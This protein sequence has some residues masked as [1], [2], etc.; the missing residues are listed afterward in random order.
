MRISISGCVYGLKIC[1]L[2]SNIL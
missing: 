2:K 1:I